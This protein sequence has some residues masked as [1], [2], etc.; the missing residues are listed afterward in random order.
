MNQALQ[1]KKNPPSDVKQMKR[2]IDEGG[3]TAERSRKEDKKPKE[4]KFVIALASKNISLSYRVVD[5]EPHVFCIK[6]T[7]NV[8]CSFLCGIKVQKGRFNECNLSVCRGNFQTL[9]EAEFVDIVDMVLAFLYENDAETITSSISK[10]DYK[11][12]VNTSKTFLNAFGMACPEDWV[13]NEHHKIC[14]KWLK[15]ADLYDLT[16]TFPKGFKISKGFTLYNTVRYES[17]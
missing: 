10:G 16:F 9:K 15:A 17:K 5:E 1:I 8:D 12:T 2:K 6:M 4:D 3:D 13:G 7:S 14:K 11:N